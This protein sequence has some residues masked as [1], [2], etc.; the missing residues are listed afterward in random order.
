MAEAAALAGHLFRDAQDAAERMDALQASLDAEQATTDDLDAECEALRREE[1]QYK[2]WI[3]DTGDAAGEAYR[4]SKTLHEEHDR[5]VVLEHEV[6]AHLLPDI[7]P[8]RPER[9]PSVVL[10]VFQ[11][12]SKL[13]AISRSLQSFSQKQGVREAS[14]SQIESNATDALRHLELLRAVERAPAAAERPG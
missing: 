13:R 10:Q 14:G 12:K 1:M 5:R 11:L 3:A 8:N 9:L 6:R 7:A 4:L 2:S